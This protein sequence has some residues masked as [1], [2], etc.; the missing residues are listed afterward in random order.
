MIEKLV[1]NIYDFLKERLSSPFLVSL[2]FSWLIINWKIVVIL[3]GTDAQMNPSQRI[4]FIEKNYVNSC[5]NYWYPLISASA[6]TVVYP[7][8]SLGISLLWSKID[9]EKKRLLNKIYRNR[10]LTLEESLELRD[11]I[12]RID[13]EFERMLK[14]KDEQIK[15]LKLQIEEL[16]VI[17]E[18]PEQKS[19]NDSSKN[20][21]FEAVE[22]IQK[23]KSAFP[24][25]EGNV[26]VII[27]RVS[28]STLLQGEGVDQGIVSFFVTNDL[29]ERTSDSQRL[30]S[31][32]QKGKLVAATFLETGYNV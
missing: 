17:D 13:S 6:Y 24:K 30:Y 23:L 26:R 20:K 32:T 2:L 8:I 28:N 16:Q 7:F 19:E 11:R 9:F 25:G 14:N 29:I 15:G 10:L 4:T 21:I 27:N 12:E 3:F 22:I 5:F 31:F 1:N 18:I